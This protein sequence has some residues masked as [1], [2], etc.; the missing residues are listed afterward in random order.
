MATRGLRGLMDRDEA[1]GGTL[2][3][4]SPAVIRAYL[5]LT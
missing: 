4:D 5:T 3:I 1:G 2:T